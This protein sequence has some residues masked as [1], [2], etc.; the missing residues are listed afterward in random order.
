[1]ATKL[2]IITKEE[3]EQIVL[4]SYTYA[5]VLKKL[6]F[7]KPTGSSY[8]CLK[9]KIKKF[10]ISTEHMTHHSNGGYHLHDNEDIFVE[11]SKVSQSTL[12]RRIKKYNLIPYKCVICGNTGEW[13]NKPLTLTLDHINGNRTD[14]RLENL[15]YLCPNC[16]KQQETFGAKNKIRYYDLDKNNTNKKI[17][18]C[19]KCG[20]TI[21]QGSNL[22]IDCYQKLKSKNIPPKE[23][24]LEELKNFTSFWELGQKYNVSDNTV[25]KWCKRYDL[26][27]RTSE[28][29]EWL[30]DCDT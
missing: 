28:V 11:N 9:D 12:R 7:I 17:Y 25:R 3:L 16:D 29:K 24:I 13:N 21:S 19:I 22:C 26:P 18:T 23:V 20:T 1:M 4:N 15:R 30:K 10:N 2:S 6:D 5:D 27:F 14:N 8:R